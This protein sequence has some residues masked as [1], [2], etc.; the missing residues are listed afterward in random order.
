MELT[1]NTV[2]LPEV[3]ELTEK[4]SPIEYMELLKTVQ[5]ADI[6]VE[7]VNVALNRSV[8]NEQVEFELV[9]GRDLRLRREVETELLLDYVIQ[10]KSGGAEVV[11]VS[12][13]YRLKLTSSDE[14]T[15][16][17]LVI[18]GRTSADMQVWPFLRELANSVTARMGIPRLILPLL[19][20]PKSL[21]GSALC[22]K[23]E[24]GEG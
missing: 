10:A 1:A 23:K 21:K 2:S 5:V 6:T 19:V 4:P 20:D 7:A 16:G 22:G 17:F 9:F 24:V 11:Q 18:Y 3:D 13:T 12:V 8:L 14:L 15:F